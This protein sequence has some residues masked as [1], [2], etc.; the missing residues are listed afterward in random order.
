MDTK[1]YVKFDYYRLHI[2]KALGNFQRSDSNNKN[3][4]CGPFPFPTTS[5]AIAGRPCDVKA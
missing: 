4:A 3:N 1:V 2:D 5:S